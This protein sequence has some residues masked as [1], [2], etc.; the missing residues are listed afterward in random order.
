MEG[1]ESNV[2]LKMCLNESSYINLPVLGKRGSAPLDHKG[3]SVGDAFGN[4]KN[5]KRF[6]CVVEEV[7]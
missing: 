6:P 5:K 3:L 4:G 2:Y 7:K 1:E